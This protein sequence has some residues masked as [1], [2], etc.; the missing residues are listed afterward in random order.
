[1]ASQQPRRKWGAADVA[2]V[3]AAAA[4]VP[5]WSRWLNER[6]T[7]RRRVKG[8]DG[9]EEEW[10]LYRPTSLLHLA[11]GFGTTFGYLAL[12]DLLVARRAIDETSRFFILHTLANVAITIAATPDAARSLLRP[13]HEPVGKMSILPVYL[14]A[15]LFTYH[16]S[17]FSNVPRNECDPRPKP[18]P[19]PPCH[20]WSHGR[21]H[22]RLSAHN[23]PARRW[24]HHVLFGGGIGGVGLVNPAS[25]LGNA[26][27]FFICG[28]PGGIDYG[29]H[30]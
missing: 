22:A 15:G 1:M 10:V 5:Q 30:T 6:Q 9:E 2:V 16:L 29:V 28:L 11:Q 26:L 12:L 14:I 13:F 17:V 18:R 27:A 19:T 25:P 24:V 23:P 21:P 20:H 7:Q 3:L 4:I 8:E